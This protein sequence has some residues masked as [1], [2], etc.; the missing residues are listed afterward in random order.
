V[1]PAVLADKIAA[2]IGDHKLVELVVRVDPDRADG[3][4]D[5]EDV[6]HALFA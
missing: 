6:A 2:T 1:Q 3:K 4:A 5:T